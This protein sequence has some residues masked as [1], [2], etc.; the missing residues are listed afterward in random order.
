VA[1]HDGIV[2][3]D[4]TPDPKFAA[5]QLITDPA[6]KW[7]TDNVPSRF[8]KADMSFNALF[9][10]EKPTGV[11]QPLIDTLAGTPLIGAEAAAPLMQSQGLQTPLALM[12]QNQNNSLDLTG[13]PEPLKAIDDAMSGPNDQSDDASALGF[14]PLP[15][16]PPLLPPGA[17]AATAATPADAVAQVPDVTPPGSDIP[18]PRVLMSNPA[19]ASTFVTQLYTRR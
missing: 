15:A 17:P 9:A 19:L 4:V 18:R 2:A 10:T 12:P 14:S 13:G 3:A 16:P 5:Q 1:Q 7:S 6:S 8:T 11:R